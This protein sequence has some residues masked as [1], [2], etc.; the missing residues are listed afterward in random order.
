MLVLGDRYSRNAELTHP[1]L[2]QY[3]QTELL[4]RRFRRLTWLIAAVFTTILVLLVLELTGHI[5]QSPFQPDLLM[6]FA[7]LLPY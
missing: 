1:V 4:N 6:D 3:G 5:P 2:N 7:L